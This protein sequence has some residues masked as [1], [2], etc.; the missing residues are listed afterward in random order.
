M[1]FFAKTIAVGVAVIRL[2]AADAVAQTP[3]AAPETPRVVVVVG[4]ATDSSVD[5]RDAWLAAAFE[6]TL[7]WRLRRIPEL[8]IMPTLRAHQARR[9]LADSPGDKPTWERVIRLLGGRVQISGALRGNP[10]ALHAKLELIDLSQTKGKVPVK[11]L[12]PGKFFDV[13]NEA[14]TWVINELHVAQLD[15]ATQALVFAPPAESPSAVEYYAKAI[16]AAR[17]DNSRDA[18]YYLEQSVNY[19]GVYRPA[20]LLLT[21]L[22]MRLKPSTRATAAVRLRRLAEHVKRLGD[23]VDE[24][25][26]VQAEGV[27]DMTTRSVEPAR[28]RF[29]AA[30]ELA[31][32]QRDPYGELLALNR[33]S[34]LYLSASTLADAK[35]SEAEKSR[36]ER[37]ALEQAA[38]W[39]R[40]A[41]D[42]LRRL[43]DVV[44]EAPSAAKL[45]LLEEKLGQYERALATHQRTLAASQAM[46]SR[47]AQATAHLFIGQCLRQLQRPE[48]AIT[49]LKS[50]IE[51][52]DAEGKPLARI[53]LA[54]LY[55][56]PAVNKPA[57][58]E[59]QFTLACK[60][61]ED[62]DL[63]NLLKA[64]RGL[65]DL[66]M[67]QQQKAKAVAT[68]TQALDVAN[69]LR[70]REA[71]A[72]R[73][74][75]EAWKSGRAP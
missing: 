33:L 22:E 66:Q 65:A 67:K 16:L 20:Q 61:L 17:A 39:Q 73:T 58:A 19:D 27:L 51:L 46:G 3:A 11:E 63:N 45:A 34:D 43:G 12:G 54:E 8:T 13:L 9:E 1:S 40:K 56:D 72:I 47:R 68:L 18:L 53:A 2:V 49:S 62:G 26:I 15:G 6:E 42:L 7:A 30:L 21:Q 55:Q 38:E 74:Q 35:Q 57:E 4:F 5:S 25:E 32:A 44:G 29:T 24:A 64:L 31:R 28:L 52:A 36:I 14:T 59:E 10:D 23:K 75:L 50:C 60:E 69:A 71:A 48:E 41:L 70:T 37:E